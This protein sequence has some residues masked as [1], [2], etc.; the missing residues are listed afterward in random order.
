M[1][2]CVIGGLKSYFYRYLSTLFLDSK[3]F[4]SDNDA[5]V[6]SNT[7]LS[8][9]TGFKFNSQVNTMKML[10]K[11]ATDM[12][13]FSLVHSPLWIWLMQPGRLFLWGI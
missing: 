9:M 12:N 7:L 4:P 1:V 2:D 10:D 8:L 11:L 3:S 6:I 13:T 5:R